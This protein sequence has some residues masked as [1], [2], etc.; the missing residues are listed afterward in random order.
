VDAFWTGDETAFRRT[1][2][3]RLAA[4]ALPEL[5]AATR[6]LAERVAVVEEAARRDPRL[7]RELARD[8]RPAGQ[9]DRTIDEIVG[10]A[11]LA[12]LAAHVLEAGARAARE[13]GSFASSLMGCREVQERLAGLASAAA[14]MSLRTC[15]LCRL[16]ERGDPDRAATESAWSLAAA[17]ALG[18]DVRA[19]ALSLLGAPW[20][21]QNLPGEDISP[22]DERTF[23]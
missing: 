16:L 18:D 10:Y 3:G 22:G 12:G 21:A 4:N 13:R 9:A 7:G 17:R 8:G 2:R 20:V 15:R 11:F 6:V 1:L 19:V 23:K 5:T 14:L